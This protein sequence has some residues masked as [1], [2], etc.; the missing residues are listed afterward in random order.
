[1][2]FRQPKNARKILEVY[3]DAYGTT[4]I[5]PCHVLEQLWQAL[6]QVRKIEMAVRVDQHPLFRGY[7]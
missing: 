5:V 2:R 4:D 7:A 1:M 3:A 6:R